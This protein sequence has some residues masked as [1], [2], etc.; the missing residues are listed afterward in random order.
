MFYTKTYSFYFTVWK[1]EHVL[2]QTFY[3]DMIVPGNISGANYQGGYKQNKNKTVE[4]KNET[5][6]IS[7]ATKHFH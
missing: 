1:Q 3:I 2:L 6:K 5:K 7:W 4:M